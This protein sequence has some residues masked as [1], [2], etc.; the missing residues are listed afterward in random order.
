MFFLLR[1]KFRSIIDLGKQPLAN[2]YLKN[3]KKLSQK[4]N[5]FVTRNVH[6]M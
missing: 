3:K 2:S 6:K 4:E 1:I 5:K